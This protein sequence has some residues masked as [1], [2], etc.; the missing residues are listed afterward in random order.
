MLFKSVAIFIYR[1]GRINAAERGN[2]SNEIDSKELNLDALD[3]V[4]GGVA[5]GGVTVGGDDVK[6]YCTG[7]GM[8]LEYQGQDRI[9]GGNTGKFVCKNPA[10]KEY[11]VIKY[12]D[13]VKW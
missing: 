13:G 1:T 11:N 5:V 2:M 3:Q 10:C 12:N 8:V 4:V 7:C 6:A 9:E